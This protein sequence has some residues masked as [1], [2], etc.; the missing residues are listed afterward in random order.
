MVRCENFFTS[1]GRY[2][3]TAKGEFDRDIS[4]M[5]AILHGDSVLSL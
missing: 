5:D 1:A 2:T 4:L 3:P